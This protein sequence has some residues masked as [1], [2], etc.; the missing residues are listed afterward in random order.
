MPTFDEQAAEWDTPE[1][2]ERAQAIA[3]LVLDAAHPA[4]DARVLELGAGT[5]LLGLA[6][7][8][9]V[10]S[11]VLADASDGMLAVAEAKIATGAYPGARTLRHVLTVDPVHEARFDLVVSLLALHHVQDTDAAMAGLAALLVP[12]GRIAIVDLEA[13]DGSFHTDPDEPVLHGYERHTL[14]ACAEAAG[15]R[16]VSFAPAWEVAKNESVYPLFLLTAT[17]SRSAG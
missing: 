15:F 6:L 5:G 10:G 9:R 1:R 4:P 2:V 7:L 11:V 16:D 8:P 3:R 14:R 12:G 17:G 13:E